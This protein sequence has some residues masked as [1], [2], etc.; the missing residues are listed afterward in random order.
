MI[1]VKKHIPNVFTSLN[2]L[3]GFFALVFASNERLSYAFLFM[4]FAS[5]F[6]FLDGFAA[7]ILHATSERGKIFDSLADI[8]SFGVVPAYI[9]YVIT[10]A[11]P[12]FFSFTFPS[13]SIYCGGL[14][15]IF[16]GLRLAKF[17]VDTRQ[18]NQ[19][20]GLPTP[21]NAILI[22][23]IGYL[24]AVGDLPFILYKEYL[25]LFALL[26]SFLLISEIR[27][28]ALKFNSF[29]INKNI[30]SYTIIAGAVILFVLWGVKAVPVIVVFYIIVSILF[31]FIDLKTSK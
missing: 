22:G 14:I 31:S 11:T 23:S 9:L 17:H 21:T 8:V 2:L 3:M 16:S 28:I 10:L 13:I 30:P 1:S 26:S 25:I 27:L 24:F 18:S 5:V 7:R 20:I 6:D 29:S 12:S 19:F 4:F 15:V